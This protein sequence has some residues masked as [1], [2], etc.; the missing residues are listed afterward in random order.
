MRERNCE[1]GVGFDLPRS[2]ISG[3]THAYTQLHLPRYQENIS[4]R[5]L[6]IPGAPFPAKTQASG[7]TRLA[8]RYVLL[9]HTVFDTSW[10]TL[11]Q[12]SPS[13]ATADNRCAFNIHISVHKIVDYRLQCVYICIYTTMAELC[14]SSC[15]KTNRV[16][17]P[18][19]P[20]PEFSK[21]ESCRTIALVSGFSRG[22]PISP[23]LAFRRCSI[24]IS[25]HP[26]RL[27][28][29]GV[30]E[31]EGQHDTRR[32]RLSPGVGG[33]KCPPIIRHRA[34]SPEEKTS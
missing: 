34:A 31:S 1:K 9:V 3:A 13:T 18:A 2:F 27:S 11:A 17:S 26:H 4:R 24:V 22:S 16:Q 23:A 10:R 21:W 32:V 12:S 19:A 8:Y 30:D 7:P 6:L 5:E 29:S 28:R 15:T 20:L 25:F 33:P 14:S